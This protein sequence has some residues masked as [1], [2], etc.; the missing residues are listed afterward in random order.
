MRAMPHL[1]NPKAVSGLRKSLVDLMARKDVQ[2]LQ[3]GASGNAGFLERY[4]EL[5]LIRAELD[6]LEEAA[7]PKIVGGIRQWL[8]EIRNAFE[9][10]WR[11]HSWMMWEYFMGAVA[12]RDLPTAHFLTSLPPECW[13]DPRHRP[14]TW[15]VTQVKTCFALFKSE[16]HLARMRLGD[17]DVL[18]LEETLPSELQRE[19]PQIQNTCRLLHA[20]VDRDAEAFHRHLLLREELRARLYRER[21]AVAPAA[22]IDLSGLGLCRLGRERGLEIKVNHTY[23]PL[24]VLDVR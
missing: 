18:V 7:T 1:P 16:E 20:L 2:K 10:G 24:E 9:L 23:L 21:N 14:V 8:S 22:L 17:L 13:Y 5:F 11:T 15:L 12:V 4:A 6:Y 3:E 19:L